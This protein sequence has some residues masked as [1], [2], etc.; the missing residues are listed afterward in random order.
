MV[1]T[2]KGDRISLPTATSDPSS[3]SQG[4]QYY[5]TTENALKIYG[6]DAEWGS[7]TFS[8]IGSQSNPAASKAVLDEQNY[9]NGDTVYIV[10]RNDQTQA[11]IWYEVG[12]NKAVVP[13]FFSSCRAYY[14][15]RSTTYG[16]PGTG[17]DLRGNMNNFSV[18]GQWGK[19]V[20][21]TNHG[22]VGSISTSYS[23]IPQVKWASSSGSGMVFGMTS[24]SDD[25][26]ISRNGNA[27]GNRTHGS[28]HSLRGNYVSNLAGSDYSRAVAFG[29]TPR[30]NYA[31]FWASDGS[32]LS[33]VESQSGSYDSMGISNFHLGSNFDPIGSEA[34]VMRLCVFNSNLSDAQ[35]NSYIDE[36]NNMWDDM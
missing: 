16:G 10:G 2:L 6:S 9:S 24:G 31:N 32:N 34:S 14:D 17:N 27:I 15:F 28:S 22:T 21:G 18:G 4:D 3:P 30:S 36:L 1:S 19:N 23:F 12:G 35:F 7:V 29:Y 8:A 13:T 26:G 5:N 33:E 11:A 20:Q 25:D